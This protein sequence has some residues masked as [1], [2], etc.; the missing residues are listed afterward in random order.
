MQ[1]ML[2]EYK[3]HTSAIFITELT[4]YYDEILSKTGGDPPHTK[5]VKESCWALVT[6]LLQT[7]LK[8]VHKV[9]RFAA[10]AVSFG[11]DSLSTNGMFL[12]AALEELRVLREFA[13]CDWR[14]HL[15]F[16]Q[17]IVRHLF[18]TCLPRAV[19]ENRKEGAGLHTLKI[20][21]LTTVT[22]CHQVLL[23]G[24]ATGMGELWAKVGLPPGKRTKFAKGT[25]GD[26]G[27]TLEI[28]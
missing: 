8:E 12:Y 11:T 23:N 18:E 17:N 3:I 27:G 2:T 14:N 15:K 7:I 5:E 25:A 6:K 1:E 26:E 9:R 19:F 4:L 16:N 13:T 24:V 10:E 22:E 21:A 28:D 20:N